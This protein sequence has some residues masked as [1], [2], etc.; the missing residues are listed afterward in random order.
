MTHKR[1]V[2]GLRR[3]A[4]LRHE[5]TV[6]RAQDAIARLEQ[7]NKPVTFPVVAQTAG[8]S[9]SWLYKHPQVKKLIQE[10]R[11]DRRRRDPA[12]THRKLHGGDEGRL[13]DPT[14]SALRQQIRELR[15]E[16]RELRHQMEI[17]YGQLRQ[18]IQPSGPSSRRRP[19]AS[20]P[21]AFTQEGGNEQ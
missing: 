18:K 21:R 5:R 16:N 10:L 7:D 9:V 1:N 15:E 13:E 14:A 8:V 17:V 19:L 3:S 6:R 11:D 4:R 12:P 2:E 20:T